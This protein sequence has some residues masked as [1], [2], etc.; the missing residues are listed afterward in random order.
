M[1]RPLLV[2]TKDVIITKNV[3]GKF[4]SSVLFLQDTKNKWSLTGKRTDRRGIPTIYHSLQLCFICS[5]D[6]VTDGVSPT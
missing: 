3:R 4:Y 1:D 6:R 2:G 5:V